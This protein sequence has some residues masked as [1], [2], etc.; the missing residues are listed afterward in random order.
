MKI[1]R[2]ALLL[3]LLLTDSAFS[4]GSISGQVVDARTDEGMSFASVIISDQGAFISG[5]TTDMN[6]DFV[7]KNI[8]S[9][10]YD[11]TSSYLGYKNDF[12]KNIDILDTGKESIFLFLEQSNTLLEMITVTASVVRYGCGTLCRGYTITS[13]DNC[14][15]G[16]KK[17]KDSPG[18]I[19][20]FTFSE[21]TYDPA[22]YPNPTSDYLWIENSKNISEILLTDVTGRRV[23]S[24]KNGISKLEMAHLKSGTYFLRYREEEQF[25][26]EKIIKI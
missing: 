5:T 12:V 4:Q 8:P 23:T 14:Y 22:V 11:I 18:T 3:F 1:S 16:S 13:E 20:G 17:E 6:G 7:I 24:Y 19:Q 26:T 21:E 10:S 15:S 9:G 2:L 25:K